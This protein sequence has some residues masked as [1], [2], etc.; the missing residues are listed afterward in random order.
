MKLINWCVILLTSLSTCILLSTTILFTVSSHAQVL[1]EIIVTSQKRAESLQDVSVS[2]TAL[3]GEKLADGAIARLEEVTA[4]VPN[5]TMSETGIGTNIYIR[6]IGSGI[7]QGFE[8]S[9]G[10]YFDG[11]YY[12]RAQ[13]A[14]SPIFD[15]E[16]LEVLKGPQVTLFGNN[17][18]GG[19]VSINSAKPTD[20][21]QGS[22]K[23]LYS[24]EHGEDE[25][26]F[27]LSG[28]ITDNLNSRLA[29]RKYDM[30]GYMFNPNKNRDEP[31]RDY[32]TT[33]LSFQFFP[34][35]DAYEANL[36]IEHSEFNV[37]GRQIAI[38]RDEPTNFRGTSAYAL[39]RQNNFAGNPASDPSFPGSPNNYLNWDNF[40]LIPFGEAPNFND[41]FKTGMDW[42]C[43]KTSNPNPEF[44]NE[45][46]SIYSIY[47]L[48]VNPNGLENRG[49][50]DD[51][52][53]NNVD[54]ITLN[55]DIRFGLGIFKLISG[56]LDYNYD[57][58]CDC[59]FTAADLVEYQSNEQYE[60]ISQEIRFSSET[61]GFLEYIVGAYYQKDNL[62]FEDYVIVLEDSAL[63]ETLSFIFRDANELS[64]IH[65]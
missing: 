26:N 43:L 28:P 41:I 39:V 30:D 16:R 55:I 50:N 47:G 53:L 56:Y 44:C 35:S 9:V 19:A 52:S 7:N 32:L 49:S 31:N 38:V 60:Q 33:R 4:F 62:H 21:F 54:N 45:N 42:R 24:P 20:Y 1:E 40:Q 2:V 58:L 63:E 57:E 25:L 48:D 11:I 10:M 13:L 65:I 6:G 59:D 23:L 22:V 36:K 51:H 5:F 64:L 29:I 61:D 27:V 12:G 18:I 15:L 34:D 14:R 3:S 8:Q 17:S 46:N 37:K